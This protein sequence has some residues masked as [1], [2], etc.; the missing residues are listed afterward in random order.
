MSAWHFKALGS[1]L[2]VVSELPSL[3]ERMN[4]LLR[5]YEPASDSVP[6]RSRYLLRTRADQLE[7]LCD[8]ETFYRSLDAEELFDAFQLD[9][10]RRL[11]AQAHG[12]WLLHAAA[13]EKGGKALVL[14]GPSNSGKSTLCRALMAEG[15]AYLSEEI[16]AL[17]VRDVDA[18]RRPLHLETPEQA[19]SLSELSSPIR[20]R[21]DS[22]SWIV[23]PPAP[24]TAGSL[25]SLGALV[26]IRYRPE[27]PTKLT[28]LSPSEALAEFWEC[29]M[30]SGLEVAQLACNVIA[31]RPCYRLDAQDVSSAIET[32]TSID[33]G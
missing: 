27:H 12:R 18:L 33:L 31:E 24:G 20:M 9:L 13:L 3:D 26:R 28:A 10:Y 25:P 21:E 1:T 4:V 30:N 17:G 15:W 14:A 22:E 32:I 16:A 23:S 6:I 29:R 7:G 19:R 2:E 8:G 5:G 11:V